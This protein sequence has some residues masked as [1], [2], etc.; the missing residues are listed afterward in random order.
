MISC[1]VYSTLR[2]PGK[3]G[4]AVLVRIALSGISFQRVKFRG[5]VP[6]QAVMVEGD[7]ER[8]Q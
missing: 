5:G 8:A 1:R 2:R 3:Q 6:T 7:V 4:D